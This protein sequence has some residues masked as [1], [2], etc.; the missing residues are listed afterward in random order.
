MNPSWAIGSKISRNYRHKSPQSA[1]EILLCFQQTKQNKIK[2]NKPRHKRSKKKMEVFFQEHSLL[3][4]TFLLNQCMAKLSTKVQNPEQSV[5]SSNIRRENIKFYAN[6]LVIYYLNK[7]WKLSLLAANNSANILHSM[8][9]SPAI[10]MIN[11]QWPTF[12]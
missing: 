5:I 7:W 6:Y 8:A 10:F 9:T 11:Y 12:L 1:A 2:Q 4:L 3:F